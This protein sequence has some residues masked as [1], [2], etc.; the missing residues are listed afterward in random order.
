MPGASGFG[1]YLRLGG[2]GFGVL[3]LLD[4]ALEYLGG[5]WPP[6]RRDPAVWGTYGDWASAIIPGLAILATYDLWRRD[7]A[8][9]V[10]VLS[11]PDMSKITLTRN[12]SNELVF[13]NDTDYTLEEI[14]LPGESSP[15]RTLD[16]RRT[17]PLGQANADRATFKLG[18][19]KYMIELNRRPVPA[20]WERD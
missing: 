11:Q 18:S 5:L 4:L 14:Q 1:R 20:D 16:G 7:R 15:S 9:S 12:N 10:T 19:T 17:L 13:R 6:L 2:L 3:V 8:R